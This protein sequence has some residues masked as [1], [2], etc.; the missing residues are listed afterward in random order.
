MFKYLQFSKSIQFSLLLMA[1][2]SLSASSFSQ[3]QI[4]N[5]CIDSSYYVQIIDS[6]SAIYG[7]NKEIPD[8]YQV[9]ILIA[10]S[11]FPELRDTRVVFKSARIKTT[12][13]ARPAIVSVL[14]RQKTHRKY[15]IRINE[16]TE[17]ESINLAQVPFDAQIGLFGHEFC[18]L[19]D[20]QERNVLG[21]FKRASQYL[22]PKKKELFEK[23]IDR[24]TIDRGLGWCLYDW[25]YYV[26]F[27]SDANTDYKKYKTKYYLEPFEIEGVIRQE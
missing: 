25:A 4:K 9:P 11:H 17:T 21:V 14:F 24:M 19:I 27:L 20:Y 1:T 22:V 5:H 7:T 15:I 8:T 23:E 2:V 13:N 3:N 16:L 12:L 10:L 18:H 6:L 26:L